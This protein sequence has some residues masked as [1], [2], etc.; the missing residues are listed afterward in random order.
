MAPRLGVSSAHVRA[1]SVG[2]VP[3]L[4][5]VLSGDPGANSKL[6][7]RSDF[8]TTAGSNRC[9]NRRRQVP[10]VALLESLTWTFSGFINSFVD[11]STSELTNVAVHL[12]VSVLDLRI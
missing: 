7:G 3:Q 1:P 4:E 6:L 12:R 11:C 9:G 5:A 8:R 2:G 10:R